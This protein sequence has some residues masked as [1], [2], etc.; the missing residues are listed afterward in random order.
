MMSPRGGDDLGVTF[1]NATGLLWTTL[2]QRGFLPAS[3]PPR[4]TLPIKEAREATCSD[5]RRK[6]REAEGQLA[7]GEYT[8]RAAMPPDLRAQAYA[9]FSSTKPAVIDGMNESFSDLAT[10]TT[11]WA[12]RHTRRPQFYT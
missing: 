11:G 2:D 8:T 3:S 10:I 12:S 4:A 9:Q 5:L 6:S 7:A 1:G